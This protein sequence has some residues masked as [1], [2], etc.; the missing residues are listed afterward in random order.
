MNKQIL[1]VTLPI[2]ATI[3]VAG[4][5]LAR[6]GDLDPP[7]GAV[8]PTMVTPEE[9]STQLVADGEDCA[10]REWST[11]GDVT[12]GNIRLFPY[13]DG[14][15]GLLHK[16]YISGSGTGYFSVTSGGLNLYGAIPPA[17]EPFVLLVNDRY[18]WAGSSVPRIYATDGTV[19][20]TTVYQPD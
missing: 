18:S 8:A 5:W 20:F 1:Y 14:G 12:S 16:L 10:P 15:S 3:V 2:C 7:P 6:A 9:I 19:Y 11:W 17:G 4:V 13:S